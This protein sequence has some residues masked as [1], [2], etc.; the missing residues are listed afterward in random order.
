M[1]SFLLLF[2]TLFAGI[3]FCQALSRNDPEVN[4]KWGNRVYVN[5]AVYGGVIQEVTWDH[6]GIMHLSLS[7][8]TTP[9]AGHTGGIE[10][11]CTSG[12]AN[13][14]PLGGFSMNNLLLIF[15]VFI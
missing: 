5:S 14:R 8:P 15:I 9:R 13:P 11:I 12:L 4:S 7:S 1:F 6:D 10:G 3:Q 2:L